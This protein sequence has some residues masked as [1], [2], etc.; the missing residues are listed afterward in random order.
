MLLTRFSKQWR[1]V[2]FSCNSLQNGRLPQCYRTVFTRKIDA[3]V[4]LTKAQADELV[5]KLSDHEKQM[6]F[7]AIQQYQSKLVKEEYEG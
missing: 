5:F 6:I 3:D 7:A 4:P 1:H 2:R